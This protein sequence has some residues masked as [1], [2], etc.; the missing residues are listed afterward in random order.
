MKLKK[1]FLG[2][3]ILCFSLVSPVIFAYESEDCAD[4]IEITF[5]YSESCS[6]CADE[7]KFLTVLK[8]RYPII[9][10]IEKEA[11]SNS[12]LLKELYQKHGVSTKM[13]GFVPATFFDEQFFIGYKDDAST[14]QEIEDYIKQIIKG[15]SSDECEEENDSDILDK[16]TLPFFGEIDVSNMSSMWL[17]MVLGTVDGF[18]ACAMTALGFLLATLVATKIRKRII[19]IGGTF[20]LVSGLVYFIFISAWLNLFLALE[21]IKAITLVVGVIIVL[22]A[23]FTLRDYFYGTICKLCEIDPDKQNIFTKIEK[24]LFKKIK[25]ISE[26]DI[27][28]LAFLAGV[29]LVAV[30]INLIELVCSFGL[31]LAFT[32]T[33]TETNSS[34]AS[35]YFNIF[36]YTLFYMLDDFLIFLLAVFTLRITNASEKY[37]KVIK[38]VSGIILFLL[39]IIMIF[40]PELLTIA[41]NLL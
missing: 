16:I 14:G 20:I 40:K 24:W 25:E 8:E 19:L 21:Q 23:L 37:L 39:G 10:I 29:A 17:A 34:V 41:Q 5:F 31:P 13:Q 12:D 30:G 9:S 2:F 11:S 33:L 7:E 32:K 3:L 6:H 22:F 27:P 1:C 15:E 18:N 4:E 28:L 35:Y 36:I 38:L 26:K